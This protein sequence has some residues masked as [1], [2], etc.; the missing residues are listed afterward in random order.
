MIPSLR[1]DIYMLKV[2]YVHLL[3]RYTQSIFTSKMF[4]YYPDSLVTL[5]PLKG[6]NDII[7]VRTVT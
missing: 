4:K 5:R 1:I 6:E 7:R 2:N 3:F